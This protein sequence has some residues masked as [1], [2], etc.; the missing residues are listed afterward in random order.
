MNAAKTLIKNFSSLV[1]SEVA[2]KIILFFLFVFV[3]LIRF[4]CRFV[5]GMLDFVDFPAPFL[6]F[7]RTYPAASGVLR[8]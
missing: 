6:D 5:W 8:P 7:G 3:V 1:M 4:M 2:S